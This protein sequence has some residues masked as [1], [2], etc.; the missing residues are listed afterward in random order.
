MVAYVS[1]HY[2]SDSRSTQTGTMSACGADCRMR[3]SSHRAR[4]LEIGEQQ[5]VGGSVW[6]N[7]VTPHAI[8]GD[9][10][11]IGP[12]RLKLWT[13]LVAKHMVAAH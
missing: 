10:Q 5:D 6:Q 8:N 1:V 7:F 2:F 13:N 9:A 3:V 12:M 11:E 4:G